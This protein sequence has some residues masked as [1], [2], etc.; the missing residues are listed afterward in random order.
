MHLYDYQER[1]QWERGG[2]E[3]Y[4][5]TTKNLFENS[6]IALQVYGIYF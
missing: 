3:P 5:L 4:F 6:S 1:I 2:D